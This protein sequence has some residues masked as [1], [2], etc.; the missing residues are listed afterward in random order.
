M[1]SNRI[2]RRTRRA[3]ATLL[4][5]AAAVFGASGPATAQDEWPEIPSYPT[6]MVPYETKDFL[7]PADLDYWNPLVNRNRLTSPFGTG[8]RIVCV[9]FHGVTTDCWQADGNGQP[10]KLIRLPANL[11]NVTGSSLPGGGPGHFVYPIL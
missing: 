10:H 7:T 9:G 2:D 3:G 11:P 5:T 1:T 8:T 6:P 4:L